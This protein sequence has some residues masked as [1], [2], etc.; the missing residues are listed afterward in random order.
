MKSILL[1]EDTPEILENLTEFFE[2][3]GYKVFGA[4]NGIMGIELAQKHAPRLI[5]CD[6]L[7]PGIDGFE[8]LRRLTSIPNT[9][10]IPFIFSTSLSERI[11]KEEAL[12]M[13]ATDYI[14]KPFNL[15]ELLIIVKKWMNASE[16]TVLN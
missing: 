10:K 4:S 2:L 13:G 5:I 1:I 11:D 7:M 3:K 9:A 8:V 6:A 14:V 16:R 12:A 15:A